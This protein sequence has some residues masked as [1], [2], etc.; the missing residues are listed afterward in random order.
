MRDAGWFGA[1]LTLLKDITHQRFVPLL[2]HPVFDIRLS[3]DPGGEMN[4]ASCRPQGDGWARQG[5][6]LEQFSGRAHTRHPATVA[7]T[8]HLFDL[9]S[10][11]KLRRR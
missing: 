3:L 7:G 5:C 2:P 8:A 10:S 6:D 1:T 11:I 9:S 4:E